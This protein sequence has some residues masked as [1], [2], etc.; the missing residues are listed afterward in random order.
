MT[1][2]YRFLVLIKLH[3][4]IQKQLISVHVVMCVN[5]MVPNQN[6]QSTCISV[7]SSVFCL[8]YPNRV[9]GMIV[10]ESS[11]SVV[12]N[13]RD[14]CK[15][16]FEYMN[17]LIYSWN[18]FQSSQQE[19]NGNNKSEKLLK[20][21]CFN[22]S[23][24]ELCQRGKYVRFSSLLYQNIQTTHSWNVQSIKSWINMLIINKLSLKYMES[25]QISIEFELKMKSWLPN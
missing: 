12:A 22:F 9:S 11:S 21:L 10:D 6:H 23:K 1:I 18:P 17:R 8:L 16:V 2:N 19:A 24:S 13:S 4:S 14:C 3:L 25:I 15:P 20:I 7:S 5:V